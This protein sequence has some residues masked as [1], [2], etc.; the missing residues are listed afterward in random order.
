[1]GR[2]Q[3]L[4][5]NLNQRRA[6]EEQR[7]VKQELKQ[8]EK[9]DRKKN[10]KLIEKEARLAAVQQMQKERKEQE[11]IMAASQTTAPTQVKPIKPLTAALNQNPIMSQNTYKQ[12]QPLNVPVD[13]HNKENSSMSQFNDTYN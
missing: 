11:S 7:K 5:E 4:A 6:I 8:K 10:S 9:D 2:E 1:E 13:Q 12:P 3:K